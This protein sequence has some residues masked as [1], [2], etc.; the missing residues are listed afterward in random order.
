MYTEY[1]RTY[2]RMCTQ[3][4]ACTVDG[5]CKGWHNTL[6][7]SVHHRGRRT[8]PP[9]FHPTGI[10]CIRATGVQLRHKPQK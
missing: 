10:E 9:K 2:I 5:D 6:S 3:A 7:L 4:Y 8:H 1:V